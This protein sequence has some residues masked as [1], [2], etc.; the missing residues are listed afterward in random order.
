VAEVHHVGLVVLL[1]FG[2]A[3]HLP[4]ALGL[5]HPIPRGQLAPR[6]VPLFD[7]L[8]EPLLP[9]A[10]LGLAVAGL[11][12]PVWMVASLTWLGHIVVD[13]GLGGGLHRPDGSRLGISVLDPRRIRAAR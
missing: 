10:T 6:A 7:A 5:G 12:A 1:A 13:W 2:I 9:A 8:H 3:P 11:L 4:V